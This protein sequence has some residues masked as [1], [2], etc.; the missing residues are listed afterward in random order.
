[1][2]LILD[3]RKA[4]AE[5][6]RRM[7]ERI[8][9]L[10][11]PPMLVIVQVGEV[12]AS[13]SYIAAK[14]HFGESVGTRVVHEKFPS[15]V[16]EA[17]LLRAVSVRS[18]DEA[19]DGIIVQLPL[20]A[21]LSFE[22]IMEAVD[23]E[24]DVDGMTAENYAAFEQ[25]Q[26]RFVPA[27]ARG[28]TELLSF[29]GVSVSGKKVAVLGRSR[30]VGTPIALRFRQLGATVTVCH[31]QTSHIHEVTHESDVVVV[32]IGKPRFVTR[33]Y[34]R[35]GQTVVDVGITVVGGEELVG[36]TPR[37]LVGDVDF[38]GVHDIVAAISPVPGGVG[39]MTVLALF[40]NLADAAGA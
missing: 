14:K 37:K 20:P 18:A 2:S 7:K 4:R 36:D 26:G 35:A 11:E 1:M 23:P 15:D 22:R 3:G 12:P 29:Y 31:S 9:R 10:A 21:H 39:P 16:S 30:L 28:V 19:V 34:L 5:L 24:K 13:S 40:E 32:A 6:G 8:G 33:E 38:E 25:G 17:E 27:T